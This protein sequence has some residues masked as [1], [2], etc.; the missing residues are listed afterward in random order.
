MEFKSNLEIA[1]LPTAPHM[2]SLAKDGVAGKA[3][4][5]REI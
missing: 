4:Q 1:C 5:S 3:G 2:R